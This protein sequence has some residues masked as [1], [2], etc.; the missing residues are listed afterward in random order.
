MFVSGCEIFGR[1][2]F[3]DET[4]TNTFYEV[5]RPLGSILVRMKK[6]ILYLPDIFFCNSRSYILSTT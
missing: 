5:R 1:R 4:Q 3:S 6:K 2:L